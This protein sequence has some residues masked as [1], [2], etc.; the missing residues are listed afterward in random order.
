M[1]LTIGGS[2]E[3]NWAGAAASVYESDVKIIFSA[4]L[5]LRD[6]DELVLY[7]RKGNGLLP[8]AVRDAAVSAHPARRRGMAAG[9]MLA[10]VGATRKV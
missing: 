9:P 7:R 6:I 10:A 8:T 3:T 4:E 5:T 1:T 2:F